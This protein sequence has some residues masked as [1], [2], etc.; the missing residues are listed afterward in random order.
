MNPNRKTAII[1]GVLIILGIVAGV[2]SVVY[3]IEEPN[4]LLQVAANEG[5]VL[6]GAFFQFM[7]IPASV[8]FALSLYP[9]LKKYHEEHYFIV[10]KKI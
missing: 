10:A 7:M 3:V 8:G 4:Y 5:Q 6:T 9:I 1:A 2:L